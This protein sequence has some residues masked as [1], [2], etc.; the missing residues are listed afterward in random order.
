MSFACVLKDEVYTYLYEDFNSFLSEEWRHCKSWARYYVSR[1]C[2]CVHENSRNRDNL[3]LGSR[4][5]E[6][7]VHVTKRLEKVET[8]PNQA[9]N[10]L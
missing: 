6:F 4:Y 9:A 5:A 8:Q 10:G 1:S 7:Q 3:L 2:L